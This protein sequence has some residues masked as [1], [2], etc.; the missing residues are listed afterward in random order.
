MEQWADA[1]TDFNLFRHKTRM[2]YSEETSIDS[3][4]AIAKHKKT[5][6]RNGFTEN[7]FLD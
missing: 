2:F 4:M 6:G 3:S 5:E 7:V 1:I